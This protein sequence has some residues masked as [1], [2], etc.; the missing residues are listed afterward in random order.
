MWPY[1]FNHLEKMQQM[2]LDMMVMS[3]ELQYAFFLKKANKLDMGNSI[4]FDGGGMGLW[5]AAM[6]SEIYLETQ[7]TTLFRSIL[8]PVVVVH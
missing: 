4:S 2:L 6:K 5:I 3:C 1:F 7:G 8:Y